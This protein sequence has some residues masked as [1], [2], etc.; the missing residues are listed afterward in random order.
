MSK[1]AQHRLKIFG[2]EPDCGGDALIERV[3]RAVPGV[4][5]VRFD[6]PRQAV[7]VEFLQDSVA[8]GEVIAAVEHTGFRA[9]ESREPCPCN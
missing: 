7:C 9:S 1:R 2:Y 4:T 6:E 8:L 3:L 5:A